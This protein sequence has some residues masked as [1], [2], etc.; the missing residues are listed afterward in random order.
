MAW[1]PI[2]LPRNQP[3]RGKYSEW[4][5]EIADDC[6]HICVYCEIGTNYFGGVRNFHI[7]H[8][9]P[10]S[11]FIELED[12]TNNLFLS[13]SICNCFKSDYWDDE[14]NCNIPNPTNGEFILNIS[15]DQN[16]LLRSTSFLHNF[17]IHKLY[18]NR[19]QLIL[20]RREKNIH[21]KIIRIKKFYQEKKLQESDLPILEKIIDIDLK[22]SNL[23]EWPVYKIKDL[24]R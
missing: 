15:K 17:M 10:K 19:V 7:D 22:F 23:N 11:K 6:S 5:E 4:K 16:G 21:D 9:K 8:Y 12:D 24:K 3:V 18:L 1:I 20:Y 14:E 2:K 13:C